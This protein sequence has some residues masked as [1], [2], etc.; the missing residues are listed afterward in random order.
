MIFHAPDTSFA[1]IKSCW[2]RAAK[3]AAAGEIDSSHPLAPAWSN[4]KLMVDAEDNGKPYTATD[5]KTIEREAA[6][7]CTFSISCL[8]WFAQKLDDYSKINLIAGDK[9]IAAML[10]EWQARMV[11]DPTKL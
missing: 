9:N 1:R 8:D 10:H 6:E 2:K 3:F 5:I 11:F 4:C 7:A